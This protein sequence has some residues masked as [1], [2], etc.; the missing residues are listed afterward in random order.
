MA[1]ETLPEPSI[2]ITTPFRP[3]LG[4]LT[5]TP[6]IAAA[7]ICLALVIASAVLAPW[8]SPHDPQLLAPALRLKPGSVQFLL[9]TDGYG[10]DV[11]SRILY[12]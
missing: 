12:G 9:G 6:I 3:A 10:R 7:T 2:P 11:L 4:F 1:I 8:L 5:A